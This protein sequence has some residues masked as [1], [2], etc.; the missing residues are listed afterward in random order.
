MTF[1]IGTVKQEG[2]TMFI[3]ALLRAILRL[4]IFMIIPVAAWL[5]FGKEQSF[6]KWNGLSPKRETNYFQWGILAVAVGITVE[7]G[8]VLLLCIHRLGVVVYT[9][10]H[11]QGGG[12]QAVP[13]ALLYAYIQIGLSEDILFRGF[14]LQ[15]L[16]SKLDFYV[17]NIM[18]AVMFGL[19]YGIPMGLQSGDWVAALVL[20]LLI[21]TF[22]YFE[23]WLAWEKFNGSIIVGWLLHGTMTFAVI[24]TML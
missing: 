23:G 18:Q 16:A 19:L 2:H 3:G 1:T 24:C 15:R 7:Y 8:A 9:N 6:A 10:N 4:I 17:A 20:T 21:G 11:L 22:G 12:L 13:A 5:I 14:L